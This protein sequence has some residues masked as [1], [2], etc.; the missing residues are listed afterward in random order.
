MSHVRT[1]RKV[2][3]VF[4][5]SSIAFI[6]FPIANSKVGSVSRRRVIISSCEYEDILIEGKAN[7]SDLDNVIVGF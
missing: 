3:K 1:V 2:I 6:Y 5:V 4:N 7:N